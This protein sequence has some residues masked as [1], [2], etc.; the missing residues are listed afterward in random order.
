M[1]MDFRTITSHVYRIGTGMRMLLEIAC[2]H[3]ALPRKE[4]RSQGLT[5]GRVGHI[6]RS[7]ALHALYVLEVSW[8]LQQASKIVAEPQN[9]CC[10]ADGGKVYSAV[11]LL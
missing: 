9:I 2:K 7:L 8:H 4:F 10:G 3:P 1:Y 5:V 6:R 11:M